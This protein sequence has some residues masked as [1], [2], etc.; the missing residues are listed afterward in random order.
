LKGYLHLSPVHLR[1]NLSNIP[2]W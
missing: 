2:S 1:E